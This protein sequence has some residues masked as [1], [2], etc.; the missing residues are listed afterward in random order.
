MAEDGGDAGGGRKEGVFC[1]PARFLGILRN[2]PPRNIFILR[3]IM[4]TVVVCVSVH[5]LL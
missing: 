4:Y 2:T 3:S 5:D 1:E